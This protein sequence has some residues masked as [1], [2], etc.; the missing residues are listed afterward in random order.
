MAES[1]N[2]DLRVMVID[3]NAH[4][5]RLIGTLLRALAVRHV[6]EARSPLAAIP[7]LMNTPPDLVIMDWSADITEAVLFVHRLRR[8]EL[9]DPRLPVLALT[10]SSHH[11]VL[12]QAWEA[13]VN[14]VASKP[15]SAVEVIQRAGALLAERER[16]AESGE[17]DADAAE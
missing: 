7:K 5:R 4:I 8:G 10:G 11:A 6:D 17:P 12:E 9:G 3:G 14:D 2:T 16:T 15:V 13:G 1:W